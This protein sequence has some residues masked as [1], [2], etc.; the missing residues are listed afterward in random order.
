MS[1]P[2]FE[3]DRFDTDFR[4]VELS[5]PEFEDDDNFPSL[6]EGV[7]FGGCCAFFPSFEARIRSH[8]QTRTSSGEK[9]GCAASI[10]HG[11]RA[12][13]LRSEVN[14]FE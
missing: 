6:E 11:E 12:C 14:N 2:G 7:A 13:G 10:L 9:A 5:D 8:A 1:L 3:M 4:C